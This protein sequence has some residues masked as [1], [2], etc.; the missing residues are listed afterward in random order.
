MVA[1]GQS[2]ADRLGRLAT[3]KVSNRLDIDDLTVNEII[4]TPWCGNDDL[5]SFLHCGDLLS[6]VASTIH[7][8]TVGDKEDSM[9]IGNNLLNMPF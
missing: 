9:N 6:S 2:R 4:E 1:R 8:H 7:A 5:Y 3:H